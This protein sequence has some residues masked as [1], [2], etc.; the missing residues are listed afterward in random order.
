M[1]TPHIQEPQFKEKPDQAETEKSQLSEQPHAEDIAA[2]D[3]AHTIPSEHTAPTENTAAE[4][5]ENAAHTLAEKAGGGAVSHAHAPAA[6]TMIA[7]HDSDAIN[8]AL[9]G[10]AT[11]RITLF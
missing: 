11:G 6:T 2:A 7:S 10:I 4:P 8:H 9:Q 5:A 3:T 1:N